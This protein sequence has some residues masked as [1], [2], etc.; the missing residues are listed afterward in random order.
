MANKRPATGTQTDAINRFA[1]QVQISFDLN[2][3]D[4]FVTSL[5]A[6]FAHYRAIPSPLGQNDRGSYRR[7]DGVDTITA[8]GMIYRCAGKFTATMTDNSRSEKRSSGGVLD[9][10]EAK[11][12]MP[13]FYDN[14]AVA[15]GKRI[16]LKPG[17]RLYLVDKGVD[18]TVVVSHKMDYKPDCDNQA[19]Y[20]IICLEDT[21]I[22]SN[23]VDYTQGVDF[24]ITPEGNIRWLSGGKNPG[25]D[26][27]TGKGR[28]YSYVV[29][30]PKEVRITGVTE[31]GERVAERM[32]YH[33]IVVRE[34]IFHNENRGDLK[35][36]LK[37]NDPKR[38]VEA[39]TSPINP[40]KY[41]IPV[42]MD[43]ITEDDSQS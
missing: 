8:N 10:S 17:D 5:G 29:A 24:I 9:P 34:Y 11:L 27:N 15:E 37:T 3:L 6:V 16:Y 33:A 12:V 21:I 2:K 25:L 35:N 28:I 31:N 39:P 38:T 26:P 23:N 30:L 42:D 20:P 43:T 32:A 7:N 14:K 40:D 4:G 1:P 22:D 13:R 19:I 18:D 36:Q 41:T